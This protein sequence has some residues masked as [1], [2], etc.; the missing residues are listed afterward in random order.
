MARTKNVAKIHGAAFYFAHISRDKMDI[1]NYFN[2]QKRTITRWAKEPEWEQ[3]LDA[4]GYEGDRK[5]LSPPRRD[6]AKNN[7]KLFKKARVTYIMAMLSGKPKHKLATITGEAVG[8][9]R[10]TIHRWAMQ[11]GW[12][13]YS[14]VS[15][16]SSS[17]K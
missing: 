13:E 5:F 9:P 17:E 12:R 7:K 1:A 16:V 15:Q 6:I 14:V 10:A 8:L 4:W 2:V 11:H 3:A